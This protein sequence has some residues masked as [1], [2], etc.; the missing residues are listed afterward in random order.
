MGDDQ[1]RKRLGSAVVA[2]VVLGAFSTL[3]DWVWARFI[4]DGAVVPGVVH[5]VLVFVILAYVLGRA[6]P[7][8]EG[9]KRLL[10]TLPLA[11]LLIAALF[12]PL[13][14]GI[15][16]VPAL[17]T[18]WVL[19]WLTLATLHRWASR[20][21]RRVSNSFVRGL[22]AALGSGL[23]F[24]AVSGMWT[25]STLASASYPLRFALWTLAFLPG[26]LALLVRL[27]APHDE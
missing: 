11:G 14:Y 4:P 19:M 18:A 6:T 10:V 16:Y 7:G 20:T 8:G 12:Y 25:N 3:G 24:W 9:T 22:I 21:G 15:G 23:A 13:A 17:I 26:F 1:T 27:P 2:A 5:G